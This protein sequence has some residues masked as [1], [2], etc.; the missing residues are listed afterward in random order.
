MSLTI[1]YFTSILL[2]CISCLGLTALCY[3]ILRQRFFKTSHLIVHAFAISQIFESSLLGILSIFQALPKPLLKV[4]F[5]VKI[6]LGVYVFISRYK[7]I[8]QWIAQYKF[9]SLTSILLIIAASLPTS[10]YDSFCAH[11]LIPRLFIEHG[12]YPIRPDYQYL[13]ALPLGAHMW[14]LPGFSWNLEGTANIISPIYTIMTLVMISYYYGKKHAYWSFLILLSMPE[15]IRV[16]LDPMMD[17]P[18]CFYALLGTTCLWR[19]LKTNGKK[20]YIDLILSGLYLSFLMAIKPTHL[21]FPIL[22][23]LFLA[24]DLLKH[25]LKLQTTLYCLIAILPGTLWY[26]KAALI[27]GNPF[28][29]YLFSNQASPLIPADISPQFSKFSLEAI[30]TYCKTI[31]F[32]H[33]WA[34]SLGPWPIIFIPILIL[35]SYRSRYL[36]YIALFFIFGFILTLY[37]TSFK[38]R[39]FIPYLILFLPAMASL[40]GRMGIWS[41][42]LLLS[43]SLFTVL[44]FTPYFVQPLYVFAKNW[45][46]DQYYQHKFQNYSAIRK[47]NQL[48]PGRILF[49]ASP[50]YWIERDHIFS[51]FSE[52]YI[53]YT[54]IK[55]LN[56]FLEQLKTLNIRFIVFDIKSTQG[57]SQHPSAHY[58]KKAYCAKQCLHWLEQLTLSGHVQKL[59]N[60]QGILTLQLL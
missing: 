22:W 5:A 13:D 50:V 59:S 38:N 34:L 45:T 6:V 54:R 56:Q 41:K 3:F 35:L 57:M 26:I 9:I 17:S 32:D 48:P 47:A 49:I 36:R 51:V 31:F 19:H 25:K 23:F 18:S 27:H 39:Y 53:D 42:R 52:T 60:E 30:T 43:T 12:G 7:Q 44:T 21:V 55:T 8:L 20:I 11:F 10:S 4:Y 40:I 14:F 46:H 24:V 15:Y 58:R 37:F 2:Q 28:Y 1:L 16:S 33:H 29:P